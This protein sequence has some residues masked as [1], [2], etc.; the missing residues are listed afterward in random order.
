MDK[1]TKVKIKHQDFIINMRSNKKKENFENTQENNATF[2]IGLYLKS[3]R[4]AKKISIKEVAEDTKIAKLYLEAIEEDN[5]DAISAE[6]YRRG[7]IKNYSKYL[8]LDPDEVLKKY[9]ET[10]I[11][12]ENKK[13]ESINYNTLEKD[14]EDFDFFQWIIIFLLIVILFGG[15]VYLFYF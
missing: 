3:Q 12:S 8:G 11:T 1:R 15:V 14:G 7:F 13:S 9:D 4:E 2:S 6:I 10:V 5:W